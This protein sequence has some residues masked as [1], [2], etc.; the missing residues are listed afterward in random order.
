MLRNNPSSAANIEP[1]LIVKFKDL[2]VNIQKRLLQQGTNKF[3]VFAVTGN[4]RLAAA[5]KA[6]SKIN[7]RFATKTK[8]DSINLEDRFST[9]TGGRDL[10]SIR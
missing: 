9:Q 1:I 4:R 3:D 6:G 2:P 5:R 8:L 7:N 10:P